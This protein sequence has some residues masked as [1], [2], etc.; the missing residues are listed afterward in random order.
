MV[1]GASSAGFTTD[2]TANESPEKNTKTT[3][4]KQQQSVIRAWMLAGAERWKKGGEARNKRLD[5]QKERAKARQVKENVTVNRSEKTVNGPGNPSTGSS[6]NSAGKS[7]SGKVNGG[8]KGTGAGPKNSSGPA[9]GGKPGGGSGNAGS[10]TAGTSRSNGGSTGGG[11]GGSKNA[12]SSSSGR[13]S[14]TGAKHDKANG[15]R[16]GGKDHPGSGKRTAGAS[17]ADSGT[18][19]KTSTHK[20]TSGTTCG[21][22]GAVKKP[23]LAGP[24]GKSGK[25]SGSTKSPSPTPGKGPAPHDK[26]PAAGTD[27]DAKPS[28]GKAQAKPGTKTDPAKLSGTPQRPDSKTTDGS[29]NTDPAKPITAKDTTT[30]PDAT[31]KN[32]TP[33]PN[34]TPKPRINLQTSREAGYRDGTRAAKAVAHAAAWRDGARDGYRDT[35]EAADR[36]KARL[37]QAHAARKYTRT[38]APPVTQPATQNIPPKPDHAPGPQPVPVASVDSTHIHL[39]EGSARPH[40]SR[41]EVRTLRNFQQRLQHKT[42]RMT[43]VA[44]ATR[45]LEQHAREQAKQITDL[46]EQA[47]AVKGGEKLAAALTK[48]ADAAEVQATKAAEIHER[49]VRSSD[50][51]KALHT[52]SETR[53]GGIYKA[54][55]DSPETAPAE[56]NYYR[57][58]GH[59]HA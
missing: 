57:E 35:T 34:G 30:K 46:L 42:D 10:P 8:G 48:L 32:T 54:V 36:E 28:P 52:N 25:D 44:D 45:T 11:A 50:A 29:K 43:V 3:S 9:G 56:M 22:T 5:V 39:G 27:K 12:G 19:P 33:R 38:E 49:A 47:R 7:L 31:S 40:I 21:D 23:G 20:Q 15:I 17:G 51:C 58:M 26:A 53:Y 18:S 6:K 59:A 4:A 55:L 16:T 1:T 2:D 24:S 37:D 13:G 41:G 14:G